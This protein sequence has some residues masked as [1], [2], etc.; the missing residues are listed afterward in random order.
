MISRK[1]SDSL[2]RKTDAPPQRLATCSFR[3]GSNGS[4]SWNGERLGPFGSRS[5]KSRCWACPSGKQGRAEGPSDTE[6]YFGR[7][8]TRYV[9]ISFPALRAL[10][11]EGKGHTFESGRVRHSKRVSCSRSGRNDC[12]GFGHDSIASFDRLC[13]KRADIV[14]KVENRTT[15]KISRKLIFRP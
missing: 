2:L 1:S 7:R 5:S 11:S 8:L 13:P 4:A 15:L 3:S 10:P 6:G 12:P 9:S 14:A